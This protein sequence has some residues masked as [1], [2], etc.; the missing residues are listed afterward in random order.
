VIE[1]KRRAAVVAIENAAD[2]SV[3]MQAANVNWKAD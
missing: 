1:K 2:I 3:A